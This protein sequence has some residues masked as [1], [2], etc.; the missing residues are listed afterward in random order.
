GAPNGIRTRTGPG[1]SRLPL[2]VGLWGPPNHPAAPAGA[3]RRE[4]GLET[5]FASVLFWPGSTGRGI[6]RRPAS[7][8]E[9]RS[10]QDEQDRP[11]RAGS[12]PV[13]RE[14]AARTVR[15]GG[16]APGRA[17]GAGV[18]ELAVG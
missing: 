12:S 3:G 1:L 11:R 16:P 5:T 4:G 2:P 18:G 9:G 14:A 17:R 15:R 10:G 6:P 13:S 8:D 7:R